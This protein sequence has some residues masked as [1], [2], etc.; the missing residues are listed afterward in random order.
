MKRKM[1]L[2]FI[3]CFAL[4]ACACGKD[5]EE[6]A[7]LGALD[8]PVSLEEAGQ[9]H[10]EQADLN[11]SGSTG[12]PSGL[13]EQEENSSV[14]LLNQQNKGSV[15][16]SSDGFY[17]I[18]YL[19][20]SPGANILYTDAASA[21]RI[22]LSP[23]LSSD[24]QSASDPS[25]LDSEIT[26]GGVTVLVANEHL[27]LANTG[28]DDTPGAIYKAE[29]D[30]SG[31][32]KL[33]EFTEHYV[34]WFTG[35]IAFD[36]EWFYVS[37]ESQTKLLGVSSVDGTVK[38]LCT[39][40][41]NVGL[42]SGAFD[43]QVLITTF[44]EP[45]GVEDMSA[46]ERYSALK[47]ALYSYHVDSGQMEE[48]MS[49]KTE[50]RI[51]YADGHLLYYFDIPGDCLKAA[52]LR[53]GGEEI[54]LASLTESGINGA[55]ISEIRTVLDGH[56]VYSDEYDHNIDLFSGRVTD[57]ASLSNYKPMVLW[58]SYGEQYLVSSGELEIPYDGYDPGGNP[59]VLVTS[60]PLLALIDK[61]DYWN[62]NYDNLVPVK[63]VFLED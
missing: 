51:I 52:D 28:L 18:H 9:D 40:P 47:T 45:E 8:G 36:G 22:Y 2:I 60:I 7:S 4:A 53:D 35:E 13:G 17:E 38:E 26:A 31:R 3:M 50:D 29:L 43:D 56:L 10:A 1:C 39:F 62:G 57:M 54:I 37:G 24:H 49:W 34:E 33:A 15:G 46:E 12:E 5:G 27:F 23:D 58:G 6:P 21:Q 48:I 41:N 30:G 20:G 16:A 32:T 11:Q 59:T 55:D 61:D 25:W 63:N 42:V 14:R 19:G 44:E